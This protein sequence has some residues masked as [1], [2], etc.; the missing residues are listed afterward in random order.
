MYYQLMYLKV[1][2]RFSNI[3]SNA[4][5]KEIVR[6]GVR[7]LVCLRQLSDY[8]SY[9]FQSATLSPTLSAWQNSKVS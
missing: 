3:I 2:L 5:D 8:T 1:M 9:H 4:H 6:G 7:W